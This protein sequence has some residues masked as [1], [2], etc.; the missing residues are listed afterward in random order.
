MPSHLSP[1]HNLANPAGFGIAAREL[2]NN[3]SL[4]PLIKKVLEDR[5]L[6]E[7]LCD[8]VYQTMLTDLQQQQ[9]RSRNY[10]GW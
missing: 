9:D 6:L 2:V 8:R 3:A 7:R 1:Q 10:G 5:A 4:T